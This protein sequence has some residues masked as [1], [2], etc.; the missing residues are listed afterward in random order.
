MVLIHEPLLSRASTQTG[1]ARQ[2]SAEEICASYL[3]NQDG[4]ISNEHPLRL[5][6]LLERLS[7]GA[8]TDEHELTLQLEIK[9]HADEQLAIET[10]QETMTQVVRHSGALRV[11]V[12]IISFWPAVAVLAAK[13]GLRARLIIACPY[14]PEAL[15]EWGAA[16]GLFGV[17][18]EG[19]YFASSALKPWRK[20]GLSVM[21]GVINDAALLEPVLS[22]QPAAV[23]TDRPHELRREIE[24]LLSAA[25][26]SPHAPV[27]APG[28]PHA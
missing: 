8:A 2:R 13:H 24:A 17:I 4:T 21:S 14:V 27:R 9:S 5:D 12:E 15:A 16:V 18:L 11:N 6:Q 26:R 23:A 22:F 25:N 10:A 28:E 19:P 3:L 7:G 20:A 1:W